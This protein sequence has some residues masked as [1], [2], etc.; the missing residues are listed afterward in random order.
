ML[1]DDVIAEEPRPLGAGVGDQGLGWVEFQSEGLPEEP[2]ELGLD[3]LGFGL[4]P[5]ESQQMVIRIPH[6]PEAAVAGVHRVGGGEPAHL[7]CQRPRLCPVSAPPRSPEQG[8]YLSVG[9]IGGSQCSPR[10]LRDQFLLDKLVELV[11]VNATEDRGYHA[12]LRNAAERV[13]VIPVFQVP[14]F[15]HVT[16]KPEEPLVVDFLR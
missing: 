13:V 6:V 8:V 7:Q 15:E 11:Q 10:V 2:C 16:D 3:L 5:G 14:G 12:A 9:G 4:R 1:D